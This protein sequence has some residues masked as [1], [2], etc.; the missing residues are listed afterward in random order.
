[1]DNQSRYRSVPDREGLR[2]FLERNDVNIPW[3][4]NDEY[5]YF[6][7]PALS[8]DDDQA[9][10]LTFEHF[11]TK[12][13][14][15]AAISDPDKYVFVMDEH[16]D[17]M[18]Y[19]HANAD[20]SFYIS[21]PLNQVIAAP[22]KPSWFD[23]LLAHFVDSYK[24]KVDK[25]EVEKQ[26]YDADIF[27]RA[28][29][30]VEK[31]LDENFAAF[32]ENGKGDLN[33]IDYIMIGGKSLRSLLIEN[34]IR[35]NSG[36]NAAPRELRDNEDQLLE[37]TYKDRAAQIVLDAMVNGVQVEFLKMDPETMK[38]V[39]DKENERRMGFSVLQPLDD[40]KNM[41]ASHKE[42]LIEEFE[43][44][45][46]FDFDFDSFG[47]SKARHAAIDACR[48][49]IIRQAALD[50]GSRFILQ[51]KRFRD[52]LF[53][54][55]IKNNGEL[56]K[57]ATTIENVN[58]PAGRTTLASHTIAY[59]LVE[60]NMSFENIMDPDA[61]KNDIEKENI[62]KVKEEAADFII[63][64]FTSGEGKLETLMDYNL[65]AAD[66]L[67]HLVDRNIRTID[68]SDSTDSE[69]GVYGDKLALLSAA[70][71][72]AKDLSQDRDPSRIPAIK[73][74]VLRAFAKLKNLNVDN[75]NLEKEL[76]SF[77]NKVTSPGGVN[78]LFDSLK[79]ANNIS[80]GVCSA[81]NTCDRAQQYA[82]SAELFRSDTAE[83]LKTKAP[84]E[85]ITSEGAYINDYLYANYI[86]N[87]KAGALSD[88][89][90]GILQKDNADA[91]F[92]AFITSGEIRKNWD[93]TIKKSGTGN[94]EK[95][96]IT[97]EKRANAA[98]DKGT[99]T[100]KRVDNS[101]LGAQPI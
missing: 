19:V 48:R 78:S 54:G 101:V 46:N 79:K 91:E 86:I 52:S 4:N 87:G 68:F 20:R 76:L 33:R 29:R 9:T 97:T 45:N 92:D 44:K 61:G 21:N 13:E 41:R 58:F 49:G 77:D 17:K 63:K 60:K 7:Y 74:T 6:Y 69:K 39:P 10:G 22:E 12:D 65:R 82:I 57:T 42:Q 70:G 25:Y 14:L 2:A 35:E 89:V 1:M 18:R 100:E 47:S 24:Q 3:N 71:Y 28:Q 36:E 55:W 99:I 62:R 51:S 23:R 5:L 38:P 11:K 15:Y 53:G 93:I 88:R 40:L 73:P 27:R 30:K 84:L 16:T 31:Q 85:K 72:V 56:P 75:K 66:K 98:N 95:I 81:T 96:E 80:T 43:R 64:Q 94:K 83:K 26:L 90:N 8:N 37:K 34:I 32:E 50:R 67:Y 59:L